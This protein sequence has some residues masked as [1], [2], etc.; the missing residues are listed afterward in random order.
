[1]KKLLFA[2]CAFAAISLLTPS[3]GFAQWENRIGIY[4]SADAA[5][6]NLLTVVP[7]DPV[8]LYF[9]VS[10]PRLPDGSGPMPSVNAFGLKVSVVPFNSIFFEA[11]KPAGA[12]DVGAGSLGGGVY[13]FNMGWP[14][15]LPVVNGMVMVME[16]IVTPLNTT[17]R[18]FYLSPPNT[19]DPTIPGLMAVNYQDANETPFLTGCTASSSAF[20]VPVFILGGANPIAT[21]SASF[22]G[23]KALFR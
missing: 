13:D 23:V 11:V 2:V 3:A 15:P 16:W 17:L 5:A 10:N 6:A 9:V 1:M 21:E 20:N 18:G 14:T 19:Q 7:G 22:G 12:I 4:T 8:S